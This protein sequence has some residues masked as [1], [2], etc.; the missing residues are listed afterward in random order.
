MVFPLLSWMRLQEYFLFFS[1]FFF[2]MAGNQKWWLVLNYAYDGSEKKSNLYNKKMRQSSSS[3]ETHYLLC[4]HSYSSLF[5]V[6]GNNS[7]TVVIP[8]IYKVHLSLTHKLQNRDWVLWC[9]SKTCNYKW[10]CFTMSVRAVVVMKQRSSMLHGSLGPRTASASAMHTL[11]QNWCSTSGDEMDNKFSAVEK[12]NVKCFT[13]L[14]QIIHYAKQ[15]T[16]LMSQLKTFNALQPFRGQIMLCVNIVI[17]KMM[18]YCA[19][20]Y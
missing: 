12:H 18:A 3:T 5:E 6:K 14:L 15:C 11:R 7:T 1:F 8:L 19:F 10:K 9:Q 16:D 13:Y 17:L 2:V 4:L 20:N